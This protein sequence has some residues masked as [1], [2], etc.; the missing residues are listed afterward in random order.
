[1]LLDAELTGMANAL[2]SIIQAPDANGVVKKRAMTALGALAPYFSDAKLDGFMSQFVEVV[3]A[4][5][6][7][8]NNR[9][10]LV[11]TTGTLARSIPKKV[12]TYLPKMLPPI[13]DVLSQEELGGDDSDNEIE[14][15]PEIEELREAALVAVEALITSCPEEMQPHLDAVLDSTV[16]FLKYD[17]NV[18]EIDDEEMGGTQDN[19]S[20]DGITEDPQDDDDEYAELDDDAAFSDVDD[21]SWKV[22][23]CAAKAMLAII[24]SGSMADYGKLFAKASPVLIS[25]LNNEREDNVRLEVIASA[26]ALIQKSSANSSSRSNSSTLR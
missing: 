12:G 1:M 2:M 21:M 6:Q 15:D 19:D 13:L 11:S 17:P 26:T 20:D 5:G 18:A 24:N 10:Y 4:H 22:R 23:R 8:A 9:R 25:R 14:V 16:R 3:S 7:L